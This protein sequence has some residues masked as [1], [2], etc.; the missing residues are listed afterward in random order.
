MEILGPPGTTKDSREKLHTVENATDCIT[1]WRSFWADVLKEEK[2]SELCKAKEETIK[3]FLD[4]ICC[5]LED[6]SGKE[7]FEC[8]VEA[9]KIEFEYKTKES[10]KVTELYRL[11]SQSK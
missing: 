7:V 8:F 6:M 5:A 4:T 11:L 3:G 9:V 2:P 1:D 10:T